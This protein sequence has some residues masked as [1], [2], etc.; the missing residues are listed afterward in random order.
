MNLG[1]PRCGAKI[2]FSEAELTGVLVD[3]VEVAVRIGAHWDLVGEYVDCFRPEQDGH[4]NLKRRIRIL[5]EIAGLIEAGEF[6]YDRKKY[7]IKTEG[8]RWGMRIVCDLQKHGFRNH[9]Y[10]KTVMINQ[11]G[12]E[13][14]SAEGLTA[15]QENELIEDQKS[16]RSEGAGLMTL[17][18]FLEKGGDRIS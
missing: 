17:G 15:K 11:G 13:R 1:C 12:A 8:I 18:E 16:R 10:L 6:Q 14:L 7:R 5:K 3:M 2:K 4:V 9:N